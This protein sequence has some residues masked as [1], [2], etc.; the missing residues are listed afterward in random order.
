MN[1]LT[2]ETQPASSEYRK[3]PGVYWRPEMNWRSES[4]L[5]TDFRPQNKNP[6]LVPSWLVSL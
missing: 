3:L 1:L 4:Q 6:P 5:L 2:Q